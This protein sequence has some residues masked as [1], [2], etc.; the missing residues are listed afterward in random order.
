MFINK[1]QRED[2]FIDLSPSPSRETVLRLYAE[3]ANMVAY[4]WRNSLFPSESG[5]TNGGD[6]Q[7]VLKPFPKIIEDI[8]LNDDFKEV[9]EY[10]RDDITDE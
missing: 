10:D 8:L 2:K 5:W 1:S 3:R 9:E 6:I 7:Y 4:I